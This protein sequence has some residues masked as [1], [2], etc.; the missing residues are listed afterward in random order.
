MLLVFMIFMKELTNQ[1]LLPGFRAVLTVHS[2]VNGGVYI[3]TAFASFLQIVK[4]KSKTMDFWVRRRPL[5][6][7]YR[8]ISGC[9]SSL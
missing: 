7:T 2:Q 9:L 1:I 3:L 5:L 8:K 4:A 6:S